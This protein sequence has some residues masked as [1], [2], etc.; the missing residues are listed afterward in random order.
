MYTR[1]FVRAGVCHPPLSLVT[2]LNGCVH[3]QTKMR[4]SWT[5]A[6]DFCTT[7]DNAE[8]YSAATPALSKQLI[9]YLK[10]N[11]YSGKLQQTI[12]RNIIIDKTGPR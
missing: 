1:V 7:I 11:G 4:L 12:G 9:V 8:L 3:V 6:R 5:A 2:E 10:K